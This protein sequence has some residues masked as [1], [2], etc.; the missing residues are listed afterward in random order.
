[1]RGH[2]MACGLGILLAAGGIT[3]PRAGAGTSEVRPWL[4]SSVPIEDRITALMSKMTLEEKA[5]ELYGVAPPQGY[6]SAGYVE[7]NPRLGI[8]PLVLSDGPAGLKDPKT[9]AV[10][11]PATAL[12][13]PI[14]L[15][16]TWSPSLA[17]EY[18]SLIGRE[19][20]A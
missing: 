15:A 12:P 14:A 3:I 20:R 19:A 11:R 5:Q 13:A 7:G 16:A 8:P 17:R 9:A 4:N 6:Y 10:H 18:G 1:M 2:W